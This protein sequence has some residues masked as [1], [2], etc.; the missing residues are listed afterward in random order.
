MDRQTARVDR[1]RLVHQAHRGRQDR[2]ISTHH[3]HREVIQDREV[4]QD[5]R[6]TAIR[7]TRPIL[8]PLTI[9]L[10]LS[11]RARRRHLVA[12]RQ[13][14]W[15]RLIPW[16]LLPVDRLLGAITPRLQ[17]MDTRPGNIRPAILALMAHQFLLLREVRLILPLLLLPLHPQARLLA[18]MRHLL[19][20]PPRLLQLLQRQAH[21]PRL[22]PQVR[23]PADRPHLHRNKDHQVVLLREL[24]PPHPQLRHKDPRMPPPHN[25][26]Q[27]PCPQGGKPPQA[28]RT[29][30]MARQVH[31]TR[32]DHRARMARRITGKVGLTRL[33]PQIKV[34]HLIP[35]IN[36]RVIPARQD[37]LILKLPLPRPKATNLT[38]AQVVTP[39][40]QAKVTHPH[41]MG[42]TDLPEVNTRPLRP[43]ITKD[44]L[45]QRKQ[46]TA[47]TGPLPR[48]R[49]PHPGI[50]PAPLVHLHPDIQ[51]IPASIPVIPEDTRATPRGVRQAVLPQAQALQA[52][53]QVL[54]LHLMQQ[55]LLH[56]YL[57]LLLEK[58]YSAFFLNI[59]L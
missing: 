35:G 58:N 53:L 2:L 55:H 41:R 49:C 56:L 23:L 44:T 3:T 30:H 51:A 34:T 18:Q 21:N 39:L 38:P 50:R 17:C 22:L 24:H 10:Q 9:P 8:K 15:P 12:S 57:V 7:V 26:P 14:L 19:L 33:H 46:A 45:L 40:P 4:H 6:Q 11:P 31:L 16:L 13:T 54:H 25:K 32:T 36:I 5:H 27:G 47:S 43:S 59:L 37:R 48:V 42:S 20:L 28:L 52:H 1:H 29:P